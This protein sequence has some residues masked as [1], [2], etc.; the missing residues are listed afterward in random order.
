MWWAAPPLAEGMAHVRLRIGSR[1]RRLPGTPLA[2]WSMGSLCENSGRP[3]L[4]KNHDLDFE[5]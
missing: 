1:A 4:F 3:S 2:S 5:R